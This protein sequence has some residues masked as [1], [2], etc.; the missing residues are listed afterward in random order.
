[1]A[2]GSWGSDKVN[3]WPNNCARGEKA[4]EAV[5]NTPLAG[6]GRAKVFDPGSP[7]DQGRGKIA[8]QP[9]GGNRSRQ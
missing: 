2:S 6:Q 9:D 5:Q 1:M 3:D 8:A 7:L 4:V